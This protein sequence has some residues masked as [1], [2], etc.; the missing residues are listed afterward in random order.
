MTV[1]AELTPPAAGS[2]TTD[3]PALIIDGNEAA[4][5]IAYAL[6]E[7][8][9][10]S[11]FGD[12]S[13]VMAARATGWAM[14]SSASVQEAHDL[15]LIAHSATLESRIP[16]LHFF[17]AFRTSHE[18]PDVTLLT[19]DDMRW[20]IDFELVLDHRSRALTPDHPIDPRQGAESRRLL[21]GA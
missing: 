17:D 21:S 19:S 10:P 8:H 6:S 14:L 2:A 7:V 16:F 3:R 5:R 1:Q 15:A 20:M 13:D 12:H 9:G 18:I 4:A 11:I